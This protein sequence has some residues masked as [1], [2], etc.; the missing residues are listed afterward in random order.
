MVMKNEYKLWEGKQEGIYS[1]KLKLSGF[2]V[3]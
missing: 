3:Q 1:D 2:Y